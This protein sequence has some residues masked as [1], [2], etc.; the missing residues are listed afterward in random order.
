MYLFIDNNGLQV[1]ERHLLGPES[2]L[3]KFT[4]SYVVTVS[5]QE[6]HLLKSI[7]GENQGRS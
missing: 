5:E 1:I 4:T 3:R 2:P 7:A 6:S